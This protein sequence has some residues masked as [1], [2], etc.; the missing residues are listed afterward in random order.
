[1]P[2]EVKGEVCPDKS[3]CH[4][5]ALPTKF[6]EKDIS[7]LL[8]RACSTM[9]KMVDRYALTIYPYSICDLF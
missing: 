1:M 5:I 9:D 6:S 4:L 3:A 7:L 8:L 2:Q